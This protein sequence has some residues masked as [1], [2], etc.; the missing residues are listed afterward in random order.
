MAIGFPELGK[1]SDP[2][3]V[4]GG[5]SSKFVPTSHG[6]VFLFFLCCKLPRASSAENCFVHERSWFA[7]TSIKTTAVLSNEF[8][9]SLLYREV[10]FFQ[11]SAPLVNIS[12]THS[13]MSFLQKATS[14]VSSGRPKRYWCPIMPDL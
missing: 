10:T 7:N 1:A 4:C 14:G 9:M 8:L 2:K 13:L 5:N 6:Q 11:Y 3:K 12:N